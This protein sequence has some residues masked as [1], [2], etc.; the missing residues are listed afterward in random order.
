MLITGLREGKPLKNCLLKVEAG[1]AE[2]LFERKWPRTP[3]GR[4]LDN[5]STAS[6]LRA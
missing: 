4:G 6:T 2:L 1:E 3:A 5:S